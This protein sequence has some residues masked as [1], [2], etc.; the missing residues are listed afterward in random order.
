MAVLGMLSRAGGQGRWRVVVITENITGT[1]T[2]VTG[3]SNVQ[4]AVASVQEA[5]TAL[6]TYTAGVSG[7]TGGSV[8]VTVTEAE[9]TANAVATTAISVSVLA[10]GS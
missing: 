7:I 6:P 3:L 4:F 10:I 2:I 1:G 9:A 5:G 8:A